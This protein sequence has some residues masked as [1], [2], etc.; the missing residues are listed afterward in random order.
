MTIIT[1]L[2]TIA[3]VSVFGFLKYARDVSR[4]ENLTR[5]DSVIELFDL[6]NGYY[7]EPEEAVDITFSGAVLWSQGKF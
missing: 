1:I 6:Q 7:P 4:L 5:I 3:F 2:A